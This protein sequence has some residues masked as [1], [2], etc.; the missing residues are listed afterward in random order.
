MAVPTDPTPGPTEIFGGYNNGC[1]AG[2]K[3]LAISG[4][5]YEVL[6]TSRNRFYG[7]ENLVE[8]LEQAGAHFDGKSPIMY[9]DLGQPRGGR[10]PGEHASHQMGL[11]VDVW[12]LHVSKWDE[13]YRE[14]LEPVILVNSDGKTLN[15]NLWRDEY[16]E[17][18]KWFSQ[19]P[20]VERIFVNAAI[21]KHLCIQHKEANWLIKLRPWFGHD[22]H[23]H[24]RLRCPADQPKCQPQ[25]APTAVECGEELDSWFKPAPPG[26]PSKA[27]PTPPILAECEALFK[28]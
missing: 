14:T 20:E 2:A 28:Q 8:M 18:L 19:K 12:L 5:G 24:V 11:D 21:K 9:G 25:G 6:H 3:T 17:W 15:P 10:M 27:K 23:F 13:S 4:P 7:H 26:P 1:I 16:G 22:E